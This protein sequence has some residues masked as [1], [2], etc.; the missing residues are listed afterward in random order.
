MISCVVQN[1]M[2]DDLSPFGKEVQRH[3]ERLR[4]S[5][6]TL[7]M[8]AN[9]GHST[10]NRL[11]RGKGDTTPETVR[12]IADA[13]GVDSLR[14]MRLAGMPLP[15]P[16]TQRDPEAEYIAQR[17]DALP[18][19]VRTK[20]ADALGAVLDTIYEVATDRNPPVGPV[21][22]PE[23]TGDELE[24]QLREFAEQIRPAFPD[25]ADLIVMR[26][27]QRQEALAEERRAQGQRR[28]S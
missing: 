22:T 10:I 9:V 4:W 23:P 5:R 13:L 7:A 25:I 1:S 15:K 27:D 16:E 20:A 18:A 17:L 24:Q 11:M 26:M 8:Y 19:P 21:A 28:A 2:A 12:A 3:L 6:R 14:L